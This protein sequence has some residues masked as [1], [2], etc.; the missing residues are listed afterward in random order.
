MLLRVLLVA[1]LS[2]V[3]VPPAS[4]RTDPQERCQDAIAGAGRMLLDRSLTILAA[5]HHAV[6]R[7]ALPAG[8]VCLD[9]RQ[10]RRRL[11][12]AAREPEHRIRRACSD[13]VVAALRPAGDCDGAG[14]VAA[15]TACL[16]AS[17]EGEAANLV[18]V[19]SAADD[20]LGAPARRCEAKAFEQVRRA[21]TVRQRSLQRCKSRPDGYQL[22]VGGACGDAAVV[23]QRDAALQAKA[24]RAITAA[25]NAAGLTGRPIGAPCDDVVRRILR[26]QLCFRLDSDPPRADPTQVETPAH[27]DVALPPRA[28]ASSCFATSTRRCRSIARPS[29]RSSSSGRS[30][31]RR[32]SAT[33]VA[34]TSLPRP[35]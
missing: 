32:T 4:A 15:L 22:P 2:A 28:R 7:G 20:Q 19:A 23:M 8:T 13:A 27:L 14:T 16:R 24:A 11:D 29:T 1:M 30:R 5:C 25:C 34:A 10:T 6:A 9:R 17:H 31:P 26:A 18:G 35:W 21:V 33:M 12:Q 3:T